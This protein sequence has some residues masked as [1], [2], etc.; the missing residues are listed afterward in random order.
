MST[1]ESNP[2]ARR[3]LWTRLGTALDSRHSQSAEKGGQMTRV[4]LSLLVAGAVL[5]LNATSAIAAASTTTVIESV[6]TSFS[7]TASCGF[8]LDWH[9]QGADKV[10]SFFDTSGTLVKSILTATGG[11]FTVTVTNPASGKTA[12]TRSETSIVIVTFNPDGS[13][14]TITQNGLAFNFVLP[15]TGTIFLDVGSVVFDSEFNP[16]RIGG[17][18]QFLAGDYAGF[19]A[20]LS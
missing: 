19:C 17:P 5:G 11:P 13:I 20:A 4:V 14:N 15:G 2:R 7:E 1:P 6:N 18:H 12:T 10:V 9:I 3:V 8:E 16:V